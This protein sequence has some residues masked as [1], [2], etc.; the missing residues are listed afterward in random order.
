MESLNETKK[1]LLQLLKD[2]PSCY[3]GH[4]GHW[5]P[6]PGTE[7]TLAAGQDYGLK[8]PS[9]VE[10]WAAIDT[11]DLDAKPPDYPWYT[12]ELVKM[13]NLLTLGGMLLDGKTE[14]LIG[15]L[16]PTL[17]KIVY[18]LIILYRP[19]LRL[20]LKFNISGFLFEMKLYNIFINSLGK[21][22][23]Y[24][25]QRRKEKSTA[26]EHVRSSWIG[27]QRKVTKYLE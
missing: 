10:E 27:L 9:K 16:Q 4:G 15:N 21:F 5:K 24:K 18:Y 25:F 26:S 22:L 8:L 12:P 6:I 20:R 14:D 7:I 13:I 23:K 1:I 19:L 3:V 2:H 11:L 17:S